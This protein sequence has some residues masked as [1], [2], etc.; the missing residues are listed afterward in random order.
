MANFHKKNF[1][2]SFVIRRVLTLV[3]SFFLAVYVTIGTTTNYHNK[4]YPKQELP[5]TRTTKI[6]TTKTGTT[7]IGTTKIGTTKIGTTKTGTTLKKHNRP[8]L[9]IF[10]CYRN[11]N[12]GIENKILFYFILF[13]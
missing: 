11:L 5:K 1:L 2:L 7:K 9:N 10:L 12:F 6:G 13:N 4:N 3:Q 8:F